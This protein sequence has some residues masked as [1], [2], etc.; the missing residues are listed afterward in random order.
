MRPI[1]CRGW[2]KRSD[3]FRFPSPPSVE[4]VNVIAERCR[5]RPGCRRYITL[6]NGCW[7]S[8]MRLYFCDLRHL[9]RTRLRYVP[10]FQ[11]S[12]F[13]LRN[14]TMSSSKAG[15][16]DEEFREQTQR[17]ILPRKHKFKSGTKLQRTEGSGKE[18]SSLEREAKIRQDKTRQDKE[19]VLPPAINHTAER[20]RLRLEFLH[21][22]L[23][24]S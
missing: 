21:G 19:R 24:R 20:L 23:Y 8:A 9:I 4:N 10:G 13:Q 2:L 16:V 11:P 12:F 22:F 1:C 7:S 17:W 18:F 5:C 6:S 15:N 14:S 3:D